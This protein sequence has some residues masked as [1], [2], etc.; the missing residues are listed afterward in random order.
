MLA[1][2]TALCACGSKTG[3]RVPDVEQ[4]CPL[5]CC[6]TT[7]L[8]IDQLMIDE[9]DAVEV[10]HTGMNLDG[11]FSG[12]TESEGC[13]H[14]DFFSATD[15]DQNRPSGCFPGRPGMW[16]PGCL[17]GVDNSLPTIV[18]SI[19]A[20]TMRPGVRIALQTQVRTSRR[21]ILV[22]VSAPGDAMVNSRVRVTVVAGF[23]TFRDCNVAFAGDAEYAID[24]RSLRAGGAGLSDATFSFDARIVAGRTVET[25]FYAAAFT[26]PLAALSP[27]I[28]DLPMHTARL[29]LTLD[30][31]GAHDGVLAGVVPGNAWVDAIAI[32]APDFRAAIEAILAGVV[33]IREPGMTACVERTVPGMPRF[34]GIS[35]GY[36]FHAIR[37]R[38]SDR[39]LDAPLAGMCG[40]P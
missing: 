15:L 9:S 26:A 25:G 1:V 40:A 37:A 17:G 36:G 20:A 2:L 13:N 30:A 22:R 12:P 6:G 31:T 5:P 3:L 18:N 28:D 14:Q 35:V 38:I 19:E 39:V 8:V 4:P 10:P 7:D 27:G 34:G 29:R 33:D 24:R 23:A 11:L 16:V 21:I 32:R